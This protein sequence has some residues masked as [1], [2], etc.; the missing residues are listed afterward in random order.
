M[1]ISLA[2]SL[3]C[4]ATLLSSQMLILYRYSLPLSLS[5]FT[6]SFLLLIQFLDNITSRCIKIILIITELSRLRW[7][8]ICEFPQQNKC[9]QQQQLKRWAR[10]SRRRDEEIYYE[11]VFPLSLS[12]NIWCYWNLKKAEN[13]NIWTIFK[14]LLKINHHSSYKKHSITIYRNM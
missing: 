13:L 1:S 10:V 7:I 12:L 5:L 6:S 4:S 3:T 11:C 8:W 2:R 9:T 14:V